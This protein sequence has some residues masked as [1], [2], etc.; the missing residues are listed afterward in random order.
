M[1]LTKVI[2][3]SSVTFRCCQCGNR[4]GWADAYVLANGDLCCERCANTIE[5]DDVQMLAL[6][7]S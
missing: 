7:E 3:L 6:I 1:D 5:L 2:R 4:T